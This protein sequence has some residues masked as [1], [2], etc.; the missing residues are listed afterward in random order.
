MYRRDRHFSAPL[1]SNLVA[2]SCELGDLELHDQATKGRTSLSLMIGADLTWLLSFKGLSQTRRGTN[3]VT[4][5]L[6]EAPT[7]QIET[8]GRYPSKSLSSLGMGKVTRSRPKWP[9]LPWRIVSLHINKC[10]L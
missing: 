1:D 6:C 5:A 4:K 10:P 8:T 9:A 7:M 2:G 3:G